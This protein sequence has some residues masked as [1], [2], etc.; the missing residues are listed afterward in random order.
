MDMA[1]AAMASMGSKSNSRIAS[2]VVVASFLL[3]AM[4]PTQVWSGDWKFKPS[5]SLNERY[6]DNVALTSVSPQSSLLTEIRP[7]FVLS[8]QGA[9]GQFSVDYGLQGLIYSHD[10]GASAHNNQLSASLK[11]NW[12]DERFFFDADARIGQQN[13]NSTAAAGTGNF[14][15]T[16]NRSETRSLSFSPAWKGRLGNQAKA[17]VRWQLTYTDSDN[18]S[19]PSAT[20]NNLNLNLSSGNEFNRVPWNFAYRVQSTDSTA[21]GNR[22]SSLSG[23]IGYIFSLKTRLSLTLG[24]DLNNGSTTS[25]NQASGLYWNLGVNWAPTP[26]TSL[27]ATAGKRYNGRSYGLDF[28]HRTRKTTWVLRYGEDITDSYGQVNGEDTYLC[29]GPQS[30]FQ[31]KVP[32]GSTPDN[33]LCP[34]PFLIAQFQPS[35]QLASGA[36]LNK[37]WNGTATYLSGKSIFSAN[38][39]KGH[40]ELLSMNSSDDTYSLGGNWTLRIGPRLNSTLSLTSMHAETATTQSDDLT[41]AWLM[42]YQISR[43]ATGQLELRRVERDSTSTAGAYEENS[44]SARINMTF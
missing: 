23:G 32:T 27:N 31:I 5:V 7:G 4:M 21:N 3:V 40:R 20:G 6:S 34:A 16:N 11:S 39:S 12:L 43:Q 35:T 25:F 44:V 26:R 15:L 8:S 2:A 22:N 33:V 29:S 9:R 14:N 13:T 10:S 37:T 17:D 36:T 38:L 19:L 42:A 28:T 18:A 41:L 1:M 24:K 30:K